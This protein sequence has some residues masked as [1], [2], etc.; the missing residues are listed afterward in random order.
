MKQ[1]SQIKIKLRS[2]SVYHLPK[3][4]EKKILKNN[5]NKFISNHLF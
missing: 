4:K 1:I 3:I 2:S 5:F